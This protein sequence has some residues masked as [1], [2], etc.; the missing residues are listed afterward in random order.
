MQQYQRRPFARAGL[1]LLLGTPTV[2]FRKSAHRRQTVL[3]QHR[4]RVNFAESMFPVCSCSLKQST[5]LAR[6]TPSFP[7]LPASSEDGERQP[8]CRNSVIGV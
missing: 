6:R 8:C 2:L 7:I 1:F 5:P 3:K 4:E